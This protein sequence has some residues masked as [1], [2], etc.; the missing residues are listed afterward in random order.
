MKIKVSILLSVSDYFQMSYWS[1]AFKTFH[2]SLYTCKTN[3]LKIGYW[4]TKTAAKKKKKKRK[5]KSS[6][7]IFV[8][9]GENQQSR[10]W[11]F[12]SGETRHARRNKKNKDEEYN[13]CKHKLGGPGYAVIILGKMINL[14]LRHFRPLLVSKSIL[15]CLYE[16]VLVKYLWFTQ[17]QVTRYMYISSRDSEKSFEPL[18]LKANKKITVITQLILTQ[19][20][21]QVARTANQ[22]IDRKQHHNS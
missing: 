8:F 20:V 21:I 9:W 2:F 4:M 6:T 17:C 12:V 1:V 13:S 19:V 5:E 18:S 3:F 14:S 11:K 10:W 16:I 22:T 15:L 7:E